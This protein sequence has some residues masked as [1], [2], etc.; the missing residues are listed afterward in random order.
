M[1]GEANENVEEVSQRQMEANQFRSQVLREVMEILQSEI[2]EEG[3]NSTNGFEYS[4]RRGRQR[5]FNEVDPFNEATAVPSFS[6]DSDFLSD[7]QREY[8]EKRQRMNKEFFTSLLA[9]AKE[10]ID[11]NKDEEEEGNVMLYTNIS[12][13]M[14]GND[15]SIQRYDYEW[16]WGDDKV[17]KEWLI[18]SEEGI[19]S[20]DDE[21]VKGN[22]EMVEVDN[23]KVTR[24]DNSMK[25]VTMKEN[26]SEE[27]VTKENIIKKVTMDDIQ[28]ESDSE[29]ALIVQTSADGSI[30]VSH[31]STMYR[32][33]SSTTTTT[34][35]TSFTDALE[36]IHSSPDDVSPTHQSTTTSSPPISS[37]SISL[38]TPTVDSSSHVSPVIPLSPKEEHQQQIEAQKELFARLIHT[39]P[40]QLRERREGLLKQYKHFSSQNAFVSEDI[41]LDITEILKIF[42]IPFIF[43]PGEAEAQCAFLEMMGLVDGVISNDSDVFAFGGKTLYKD[44]FVDNQYVQAYKI[45]DIE[46]ELGLSRERIIEFAMLEGCD[47]CDV[48]ELSTVNI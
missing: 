31:T 6:K 39:T 25:E 27:A 33:Q 42:G 48:T 28:S 9:G 12:E 47:Y 7:F 30:I 20:K 18:D 32:D 5:V 43:A 44:F 35:V 14:K 3:A 21:G 45:E 38:Q 19:V 13:L 16:E 1:I 2:P 40:T 46:K 36:K 15:P 11:D 17:L 8:E 23:E 41:V 24:K 26:T 4:Y 34:L 37:T 29:D 10:R 22:E